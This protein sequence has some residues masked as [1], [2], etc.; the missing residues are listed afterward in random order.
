MKDIPYMVITTSDKKEILKRIAKS[1]VEKNLASCVQ[2]ISEVE[3]FYKW[4]G[5]LEISN[6]Y[7]AYIKTSFNKYKE[8]EEDIL[9]LHNYELPEI[10]SFKIDNGYK[11]YIH[12]L[13]K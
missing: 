2:I 1:L 13:L 5:K 10:I 11:P 8:V 6:E 7:L 9:S 3:S 12:W 4:E